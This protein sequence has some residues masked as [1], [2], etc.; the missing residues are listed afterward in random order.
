MEKTHYKS[1]ST[2]DTVPLV[3]SS[4]WKAI[5]LHVLNVTIW[6]VK[7]NYLNC[8]T[9]GSSQQGAMYL[10]LYVGDKWEIQP[11][12]EWISFCFILLS[13]HLE[14]SVCA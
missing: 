8:V 2:E 6:D 9:N 13:H 10:K 4:V 12:I 7:A 5:K 11:I 1:I 3:T 14:I